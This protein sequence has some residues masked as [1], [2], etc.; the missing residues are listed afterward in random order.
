MALIGNGAQSEFQALAFHRLLG[1]REL[2]LYDTDPSATGK[3]LANLEA[4]RLEGSRSLRCGS[5]DEAVRGADIITTVTADKRRAKVLNAD[6]VQG[7]VHINAV[8]GDCPGKTELNLDILL[9]EDARIVVEYEPQSRLE[10]EIQQLPLDRPVV[11]FADVISRRIVGRA[12]PE[13]VTIFDSVGF[14]LE[15]FSTLRYLFRINR[16][17]GG[18]REYIDLVPDMDDP[19]DLY[20]TLR[21]RRRRQ[22]QA[23]IK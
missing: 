16:E 12:K 21:G 7:G 6:H 22:G 9:R 10:G 1:I 18:R 19:K 14:A 8:G 5:V 20:G 2:R 13:D 23:A 4:M 3:L 11:E 15:D 17:R